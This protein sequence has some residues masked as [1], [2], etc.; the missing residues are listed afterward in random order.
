MPD[1]CSEECSPRRPAQSGWVR[2]KRLEDLM[3]WLRGSFAGVFCL[4]AVGGC[5]DSVG[6]DRLTLSF[7]RYTGEGIDQADFVSGASASVDVCQGL[8][9]STGGGGQLEFETFT[10]TLANAVF[11][12]R[13]KADIQLQSYTVEVVD[14]GFPILNRSIS[15]NI[16]GGRCAGDPQFQCASDFECGLGLCVRRE[17]FV[18][19]LLYDLEVK[20]IAIDGECPLNLDDLTITGGSVIPRNYEV[21]INFTGEDQTTKR[22]TISTGYASTFADFDNCED[23]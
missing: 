23:Q 4:F 7:E 6:E 18:P 14:S 11:V 2:R 20:Q 3:W 12:N 5:G 9:M 21:I 22:R 19:I 16:P 10:E 15:A 17:T 13:G 8:C 1:F